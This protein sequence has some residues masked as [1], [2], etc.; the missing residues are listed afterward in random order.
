MR[1]L[2]FAAC[3]VLIVAGAAFGARSARTPLIAFTL[4]DGSHTRI[5]AV[6]P[7]GT[8]LRKVSRFTNRLAVS[9]SDPAWSPDGS[10]IAFAHYRVTA[11]G[12]VDV[13][14][15]RRDGTNARRLT[16]NPISDSAPAWS[17]AGDTIAFVRETLSEDGSSIYLTDTTGLVVRRLT[18]G[19][20]ADDS[21][22]WSPDGSTIA[23]A[24]GYA[25]PA[26]ADQ[27]ADLYAVNPDGSGLR[28]LGIRGSQPAWSPDGGRIAFVSVRNK[29]GQVCDR[30]GCAWAGEIYVAR[31]DGSA[32]LRLTRSKAAD[33]HPTWSP[34][35]RTIAFGS[36]KKLWLVPAAGGAPRLLA[37][38]RGPAGQPAW[39]RR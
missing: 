5:Y 19:G 9:E 6:R 38:L 34:D 32:T 27:P 11:Q 10:Q 21:P 18:S 26:S 25:D 13:Y 14:I 39:S 28:P 37:K 36:G 7:D 33:S 8:G 1:A 35:G 2:P 17:P 20:F 3:L 22:A 16:D 31:S 4:V 23:F 15:A 24:R 29:N 12:M 30:D